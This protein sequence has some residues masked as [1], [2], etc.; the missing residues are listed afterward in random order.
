MICGTHDK[1]ERPPPVGMVAAEVL[2]L[3][4]TSGGGAPLLM[5][6]SVRTMVSKTL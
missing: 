3:I 4:S 1:S 5:V 2:N 6:A